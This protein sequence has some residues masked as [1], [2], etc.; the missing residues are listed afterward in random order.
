[1]GGGGRSVYSSRSHSGSL[2]VDCP[3]PHQ[4]VSAAR[5]PFWYMYSLWI[6]AELLPL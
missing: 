2:L 5:D 3:T 6:L 1:M 4:A